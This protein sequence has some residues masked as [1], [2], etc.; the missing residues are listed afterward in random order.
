MFW[1]FEFG[2]ERTGF[3]SGIPIKFLEKAIN[4][5]PGSNSNRHF[6]VR[7]IFLTVSEKI[8]FTK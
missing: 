8:V 6:V 4:I 2:L 7:S 5:A 1:I 3:A